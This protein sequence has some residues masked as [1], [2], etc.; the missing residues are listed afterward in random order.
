[1]PSTAARRE[2]LRV[3]VGVV[4]D[5]H[6][7]VL[8]A[9]RAAHSHQGGCWEFPGGKVEV[10]ES[11]SMALRRELAEELG[12]RVRHCQP[13]MRIAHDYAD[14]RVILE[15]RRVERWSGTARGREGQPIEWRRPDA[16]VAADFPA[17]NRGIINALR[18]PAH[19]V[20]SADCQSP[21]AWLAALDGVLARGERLIQFRV[22]GTAQR[23]RQLAGQALMRCRAAAAR[24]LI[25][26]DIDLAVSLGAD[27]VHLTSRELGRLSE[28]PL[29]P[30][31]WVAASCHDPRELQRAAELG[32]DFVVLSP[33]AP[34]PSHPGA[35]PIGWARF[36]EWAAASALPVFALGGMRPADTARAREQGGQGVAGISGF[37]TAAGA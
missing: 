32:V 28:R 29:A 13:L 1:M 24:L 18:L 23:R 8:V 35:R 33:V 37:W 26:A 5:R 16:L 9:R 10:G 34:T 11:V 36:G 19:Y 12:I 30:G 15:V 27:G 2:P 6:G 17:A 14:R 22:R 21:T 25:N 3:A 31:Q 7:R 20:I 4:H